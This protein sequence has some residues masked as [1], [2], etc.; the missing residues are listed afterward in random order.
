[1]PNEPVLQV[2]QEFDSEPESEEEIAPIDQEPCYN[3]HVSLDK[4][5]YKSND[6]IF[7]EVYLV[8]PK[9][10]KPYI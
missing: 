2:E 1:M 10:Q 3:A 7:V 9:T 8:D 4:P 6:T 5:I